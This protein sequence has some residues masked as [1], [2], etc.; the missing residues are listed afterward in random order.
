MEHILVPTDFTIGSLQPVA[1]LAEA[2]P[3]RNFTI[4][5]AH[6][7]DMPDSITELLVL[8]RSIPVSTL[9]SDEIRAACKKLKDQYGSTI[10]SIIFKPVYG[11]AT[12]IFH[13]VLEA[14][15]IDTIL[16]DETYAY[17]KPHAYSVDFRRL[18]KKAPVQV[19]K[20]SM[21]KKAVPVTTKEAAVYAEVIV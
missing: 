14:N 3:A 18:L 2:F 10:R 1:R 7:F 4:V 12:H 11:Q 8:H 17:V 5:L 15:N 6:V 19:L 20:A 16:Y 9:F 21:L 13:Q